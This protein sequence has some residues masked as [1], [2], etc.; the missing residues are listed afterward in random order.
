MGAKPSAPAQA[1]PG[2]APPKTN[3]LDDPSGWQTLR[4]IHIRTARMIKRF[5]WVVMAAHHGDRTGL[6]HALESVQELGT[7]AEQIMNAQ[8]EGHQLREAEALLNQIIDLDELLKQANQIVG[9]D[10]PTAPQPRK[11]KPAKNWQTIQGVHHRVAGMIGRLGR[12]LIR[13]RHGR[14]LARGHYAETLEEL[15]EDLVSMHDQVA[16]PDRKRDLLALRIQVEGM[17]ILIEK[18]APFKK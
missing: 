5:G 18:L 9:A 4:G 17:L 12:V 13:N 11:P 6:N 15:A 14:S 7:E 8:E 3:E 1:S 10:G 2:D 16:D